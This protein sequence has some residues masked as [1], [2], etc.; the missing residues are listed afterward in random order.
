LPVSVAASYDAAVPAKPRR[1]RRFIAAL[2][3]AFRWQPTTYPQ[4]WSLAVGNGLSVALVVLAV[5]SA[6]DTSIAYPI[7]IAVVTAAVT[8]LSAGAGGSLRLSRRRDAAVVADWERR[9]LGVAP[10]SRTEQAQK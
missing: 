6:F 8:T 3:R 10:R 1:F 4:V 7:S 5:R 9:I 2:A